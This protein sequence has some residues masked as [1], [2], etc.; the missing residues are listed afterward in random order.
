MLLQ[1]LL[2]SVTSLC[3]LLVTD[4]A[5]QTFCA[6]AAYTV[7]YRLRQRR[8]AQYLVNFIP[9]DIHRESKTKLHTLVHNFTKY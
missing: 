5:L 6:L 2:Q 3:C 1:L 7:N 8:P 9:D 4:D